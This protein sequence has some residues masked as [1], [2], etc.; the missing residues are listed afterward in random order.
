VATSTTK[1]LAVSI[2]TR[3]SDE[4]VTATS[5]HRHV[6]GHRS[7]LSA[8]RLSHRSSPWPSGFTYA[9][10]AAGNDIS[11]FS[12]TRTNGTVAVTLTGD[13]VAGTAHLE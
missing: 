10:T 5:P 13:A 3:R 9:P 4:T 11:S 6:H 1:T 7:V 12:I 2:T 8:G